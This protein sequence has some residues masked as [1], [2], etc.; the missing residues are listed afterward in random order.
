MESV[1]LLPLEYRNVEMSHQP[2]RALTHLTANRSIF[3]MNGVEMS[4]QPERA[5]NL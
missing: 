4:H 1:Q 3:F 2:E 5:L